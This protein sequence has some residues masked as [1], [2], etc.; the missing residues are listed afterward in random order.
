MTEEDVFFI[1]KPSVVATGRV[2]PGSLR[3]GD[4]VRVNGG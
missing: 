3:V 2:A 4:E 1:K